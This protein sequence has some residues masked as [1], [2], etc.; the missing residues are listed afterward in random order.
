MDYSQCNDEVLI[1]LYQEGDEKA[2]DQLFERYKNL[3]RKKAKAMFLAGGDSDDL[4]QEGM[5]G[6]YKAVRDYHTDKEATFATFASM[7]INRQIITAV[8][9]SNRKKNSPLNGYVSLDQPARSDED[10]D[11]KL[12]DV[13]QS[14]S[15]QD[16]EKLLIDREYTK[17]LQELVEAAMSPFERQVLAMYMEGKDYIEIS[18]QL[19][20]PTKSIDNAIQRIR[21]KVDKIKN[22]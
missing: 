2:I 19:G 7:C 13:I 20:K 10:Y 22:L 14:G 12:I 5:I 8:T 18:R 16:P 11:M 9:T 15:E 4:I 21:N 6:L 1:A 17:N 3:V